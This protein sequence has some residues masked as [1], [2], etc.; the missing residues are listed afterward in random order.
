MKYIGYFMPVMFFF[1]L[2]SFPAGLTYYYF[3]SSVLTFGQQVVIRGMINDD[4]IHAI[5][6]ANKKK[7]ESTKKKSK[8]QQRMDDYMREQQKNKKK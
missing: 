3:L 2:N 4:K 8:F 5:I 1:V 7:P 6:Q